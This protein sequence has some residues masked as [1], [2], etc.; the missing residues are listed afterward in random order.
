MASAGPDVR[1]TTIEV[2]ANHKRVAEE[3]IEHA[4]LSDRIEVLLGAGV[5]VLPKV[6]HEVESGQRPKFDLVFIDADKPS[7]LN[8]YNEAILMC[9]SRGC[10]I[11]DNVVR[12]GR[13]V[14][15]QYSTTDDK[16]IGARKAIGAAGMVSVPSSYFGDTLRT[17]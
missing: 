8:Y 11:V 9:R 10:L 3:A 15:P 4:G 1:V 16:V 12:Q 6:R 2:D 14:D 17:N 13:I 5:E 7:N